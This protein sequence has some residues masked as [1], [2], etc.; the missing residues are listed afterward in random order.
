MKTKKVLLTRAQGGLFD[1]GQ[2]NSHSIDSIVDQTADLL[3]ERLEWLQHSPGGV[4]LNP[5][6][7]KFLT[8]LCY[9]HVR[10]WQSYAKLILIRLIEHKD[11]MI[12]VAHFSITTFSGTQRFLLYV[13]I[14]C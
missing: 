1:V 4:K 14:L 3:S 7:T 12:V 8:K 2:V 5:Q 9:H 6:M 13:E 10:I 11:K